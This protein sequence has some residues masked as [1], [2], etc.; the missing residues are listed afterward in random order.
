MSAPDLKAEILAALSGTTAQHPMDT[1]AIITKTRCQRGRV[2]VALYELYQ[3]R[4][5]CCCKI[6]KHT[7]V[8]VVWWVSGNVASQTEFYGKGKQA[9]A[10]PKQPAKRRSRMGEFSRN[11]LAHIRA[12]PGRTTVE[13][14]DQLNLR[15]QKERDRVA[16]TIYNLVKIGL[17]RSEGKLREKRYFPNEVAQ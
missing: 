15:K 2:E 10:A 5:V 3:A 4:V 17:L 14:C 7:S 6:A 12:N 1:H 16:Y 9:T 11:L 13:H 8:Q